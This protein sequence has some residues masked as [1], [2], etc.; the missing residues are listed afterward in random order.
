MFSIQYFTFLTLKMF[1]IN[2][3]KLIK[4]RI[5]TTDKKATLRNNGLKKDYV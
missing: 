2:G 5:K 4:L 1:F 3:T